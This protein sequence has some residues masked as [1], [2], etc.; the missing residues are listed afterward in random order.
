M[1]T[2][3]KKSNT[4]FTKS[5]LFIIGAGIWVLVLQNGGVLPSNQDVYVNGGNLRVSG[6]VDVDNTVDVSGYLDVNLEAIN[7]KSNAFYRDTDGEYILIPVF[8][9]Q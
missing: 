7:G 4:L 3:E 8:L 9:R 2:T 6:S 5:M 1:E